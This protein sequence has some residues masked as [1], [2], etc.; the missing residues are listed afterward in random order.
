VS[1]AVL[2]SGADILSMS[3]LPKY[4]A[5]LI[6]EEVQKSSRGAYLRV[7]GRMIDNL[8]GPE[9]Q[10]EDEIKARIAALT[11]ED[12]LLIKENVGWTC[13]DGRRR[14]QNSAATACTEMN[15][16]LIYA[17][18]PHRVKVPRRVRVVRIP[19]N[20]DESMRLLQA[21]GE[22]RIR[23]LAVRNRAI[24]ALF[25]EGAVR[26]GSFNILLEDLVLD[27]GYVVIRDTKN[28]D[29]IRIDLAEVAVEAIRDYLRIRPS[30]KNAQED[31]WTFISMQGN[32]LCDNVAYV[33]IKEAAAKA[34][35]SR[36]VFPHLLRHTKLTD[37]ANKDVNAFKIQK[38]AGHKVITSTEPYIHAG[39]MQQHADIVA[40]ALLPSARIAGPNVRI[41]GGHDNDTVVASLTMLLASGKIDEATFAKAL[42]VIAD[43]VVA[44]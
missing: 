3:R 15:S 32:R 6:G 10:T 33:V 42:D 19:L 8:S 28:G 7:A 29:D 16:F 37:L 4:E 31:R 13:E 35:I 14:K 39:G 26:R 18:C 20:I 40:A 25:Q 2:T 43:K 12:L 30:G 34:G 27:E 36:N 23:E 24:V 21:A 17:G 11:K 22:N 9:P 5:W 1:E 44:R 41:E 38:F